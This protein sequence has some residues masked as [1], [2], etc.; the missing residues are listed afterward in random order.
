MLKGVSPLIGTV[1][2][3]LI[4]VGAVSLVLT[5]GKPV[6]ER[7][8]EYGIISEALQNMQ[9]FDTL[10]REVAS[11][12]VGALRTV[13]LKVSGGEYK[14]NQQTNSIDFTFAALYPP[15]SPGTVIKEGN[16]LISSEANAKAY[17]T[18]NELILEN[19]VL[20]I[21]IQKVGN[22]TNHQPINTSANI[23]SI[24]FKNNNATIY[25]EDS[26]VIINDLPSSSYGTGYSK[27]VKIGDNLPQAE[28][29]VYVNSTL[30]SY[31]ILYSLPSG[32]DFIIVKIQKYI[33]SD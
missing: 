33:I 24:T 26:S 28:A 27:L 18:E 2:V 15:Y 8:R 19:E 3:V 22:E 21:S 4:T 13:Q 29:I 20:K 16:L 17:E 10:I 1:I 11:E 6:I 23:R 32:A 7:S 14:I 9:T 31:E 5:I 25:P 12:G 30:I